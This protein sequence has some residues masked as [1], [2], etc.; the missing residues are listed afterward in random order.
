MKSNRSVFV[1]FFLSLML[2]GSAAALAYQVRHFKYER[3]PNPTKEFEARLIDVDETKHNIAKKEETARR[4]SNMVFAQTRS[5]QSL[6]TPHPRPSPTPRPKPSPTPVT[7]GKKWQVE[8]VQK[9]YAFLRKYN[10][11]SLPAKKGDLMKDEIYGDFTIEELI[12]DA[13]MPRVKVKHVQTGTIAEITQQMKS[14]SAPKPKPKPK[15]K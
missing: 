1:Y 15:R 3:D 9:N 11:D 14:T 6:A 7:P 5:F 10:G 13:M 8:M 4:N 2:I 12:P